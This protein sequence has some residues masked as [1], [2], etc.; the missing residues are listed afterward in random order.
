MVKPNP[1]ADLM[2]GGAA[3]VKGNRGT[4]REGRETNNNTIV[5]GIA[6]EINGEGSV[7]EKTVIDVWTIESNGVD[8]ESL[9]T[10]TTE[11]GLHLRLL[12]GSG[13]DIIEPISVLG[14]GDFDKLEAET[15][16]LV[17]IVQDF[18]LFLDLVAP[19]TRYV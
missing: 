6:A 12:W 10:T 3:Q 15:G 11:L 14:P 4:S 7:S 8:V 9:F 2:C 17:V 5:L 18:D 19:G 16:F 1:V 13:P